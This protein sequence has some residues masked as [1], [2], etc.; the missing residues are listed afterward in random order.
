ML[1]VVNKVN[2]DI[3][4]VAFSPVDENI[5]DVLDAEEIYEYIL[6]GVEESG[7]EMKVDED[8]FTAVF[9][10][11]A[12]ELGDND[13]VISKTDVLDL[14]ERVLDGTFKFSDNFRRDL[15][16]LMDEDT[17]EKV[18]VPELLEV[19]RKIGI[20]LLD[21]NLVRLGLRLTFKIFDIPIPAGDIA[22][23]FDI[24]KQVGKKMEQGGSDI[25]VSD[26]VISEI[27][28]KLDKD[29]DG[30]AS[31]QELI[32]FSEGLVKDKA[33]EETKKK[34]RELLKIIFDQIDKDGNEGISKDELKGLA[35]ST[36]C[37]LQKGVFYQSY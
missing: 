17:D 27:S 11:L 15:L 16:S 6:Q 30:V 8:F 2:E 33:S 14:K 4:D 18:S 26:D 20:E 37:L 28:A 13:E 34:N 12:R 22:L 10:A 32:D 7:G 31:L 24:W 3:I 29:D 1:S 19:V 21:A 35:T 5:D 23:T 25:H 36:V 9:E